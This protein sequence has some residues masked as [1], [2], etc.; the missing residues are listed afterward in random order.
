M[1]HLCPADR[2]QYVLISDVVAVTG[3]VQTDGAF[4]I[5][6]VLTEVRTCAGYSFYGSRIL[7]VMCNFCSRDL[8]T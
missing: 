7:Y 8:A 2:K 1:L 3:H 6:W 5:W 4:Q